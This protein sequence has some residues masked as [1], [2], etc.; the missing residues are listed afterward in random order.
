[1]AWQ[2]VHR[3][4]P[5]LGRQRGC[6]ERPNYSHSHMVAFF[7]QDVFNLCLIPTSFKPSM[8]HYLFCKTCL[9]IKSVQV[10]Q[11]LNFM[12]VHYNEH[13]IINIHENNT[14]YNAKD[15]DNM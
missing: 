8:M 6:L 7:F 14:Q 2:V 11:T 9:I 1:M 12:H 5:Q 10:V 4:Q 3:A 13:V 15:S